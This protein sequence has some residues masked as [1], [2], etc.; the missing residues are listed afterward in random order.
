[1]L[2]RS[3]EMPRFARAHPPNWAKV[4]LPRTCKVIHFRHCTNKLSCA[5]KLLALATHPCLEAAD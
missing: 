3:F 4:A 1:M 5:E 2:S